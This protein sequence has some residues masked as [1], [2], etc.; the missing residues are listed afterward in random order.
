MF[1]RAGKIGF[2][3]AATARPASTAAGF[4]GAARPVLLAGATS[5][6]AVS[7]GL[8]YTLQAAEAPVDLEG[9]KKAVAKKLQDDENMG[10]TL[11][12][13][14]LCRPNPLSVLSPT[15]I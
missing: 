15:R 7:L 12:R 2:R 8:G 11:V 1:A 5:V 3:A 14:Q 6:A 13:P 9:V 10:P 4:R